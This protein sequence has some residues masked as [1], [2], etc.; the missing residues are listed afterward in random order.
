MIAL[1]RIGG[2]FAECH[3]D[4]RDGQQMVDHGAQTVGVQAHQ[5][6]EEIIEK[7]KDEAGGEGIWNE[8]FLKKCNPGPDKSG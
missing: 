1:A 7:E 8:I 5:R 4:E 3:G 2:T 6:C